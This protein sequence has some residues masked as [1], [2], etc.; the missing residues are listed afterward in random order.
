MKK[1]LF[2][3]SGFFWM[4]ETLAGDPVKIITTQASSNHDKIH[5]AVDGDPKTYW[6]SGVDVVGEKVWFS[7]SLNKAVHVNQVMINPGK[8]K[9]SHENNYR[10][11]VTVDPMNWGRPVEHRLAAGKELVFSFEP[12][13]GLHVI[14]ENEKTQNSDPWAVYEVGFRYEEIAMGP[15]VDDSAK[16]IYL[17]ADQPVDIRVRDLLSGMTVEQKLRLLHEGWGIPGIPELKVPKINKVEAL[18]GFGYGI[19]A[20]IFPQSIGLGATW[21]VDLIRKVGIAIGGETKIAGVQQAWSP[22]LDV[23]QDARWGRVEETYGEDPYLVSQIGGAW[24]EGFQS[25]G[26]ITTPKHFGGHGAPLGGRDSHDIGLS[27]REF[28]E[29]HLVPFRHVVKKYKPQSLMNAY[30]DYL[31]N[32]AAGSE[33]LLIRILR[34]EWGF[35]G[36]I[37]S[38]CGSI[39]NMTHRKHYVAETTA[40]AAN[41][42]LAAGVAT[43]CGDVYNS[44]EVL[45]AVKK[46]LIDEKALDFTCSTILGVMF[47]M[48]YFEDPPKSSINWDEPYKGWNTPESKML[49]RQAARES[50][51]LLKNENRI[52]PLSKEVKSIGIIGP[53]A[54]VLQ[55]GD[56]TCKAIEGQLVTVLDGIKSAVGEKTTVN[57]AKG[58]DHLSDDTSG[59]AEAVN[60]AE[61]SDIIVMVIGDKSNELGGKNTSGEG[62]DLAS[63][64]FTG[65]QEQLL[66]EVSQ[67]GKPVILVLQNGRPLDLSVASD[68]ADAILVTWFPGQ[69]GGHATAD[70]LFGDYNPAGRLPI[71]FPKSA[72]Q[73]PLYYNFKTS[74]R[75]YKYVDLDFYPKYSF[76]FGLSYTTFEYGNLKINHQPDGSVLVQADITNTGA[77]AGDEVAQLYV[78]DMYSGVK[79]R[80]MELKGFQRIKLQ[81]NQTKTVNFLLRPYDLSLLNVEMERVLEPGA[82]KIMV[83]GSSPSFKAG[84][85]IKQR[86]G[87]EN[88]TKGVSGIMEIHK[89]YKADFY[90]ELLSPQD[91]LL[92]TEGLVN[93]KVVN[94]GTLTDAGKLS[95]YLNGLFT[96]EIHHFELDPGE[97]KVI[98]FTIKPTLQGPNHVTCVA[99]NKVAHSLIVAK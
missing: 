23:A 75:D 56:Y 63:L 89:E 15:G 93:V 84:D 86:V 97:E 90:I 46:G 62:Y 91:L 12:K 3:C 24:I 78:T 47:R 34:E 28:R 58:C 92:N 94:N 51:V 40:E 53:N 4:L 50:I 32:P 60:V 11:Y 74:G 37:V 42:A 26:L 45:E 67:T 88:N 64:K 1:F 77:L 27:E 25:L 43:N 68:H 82:F 36:F 9:K 29:V 10:I 21:N 16:P 59:I 18:H 80:V 72:H 99:K 22:V 61:A 38:D 76:G 57:Y 70:V 79:T 96:G 39:R 49:A 20:T 54:D 87:F 65:P 55:T 41:K 2:L 6:K 44:Q 13:Y 7:F 14:V 19:G 69:E 71:T 73:L 98:G 30:S 66:K 83:G 35:N 5:L 52:L 33:E 17:Q 48:G 85:K 95:M 8:K 31:G 81:P